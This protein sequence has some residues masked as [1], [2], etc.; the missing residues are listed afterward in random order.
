[1]TCGTTMRS[2]CSVPEFRSAFVAYIEWGTRM[3]RQN[4]QPG[5]DVLRDAPVPHWGWGVAPPYQP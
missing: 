2:V 1:M 4:S 3:A 5:A